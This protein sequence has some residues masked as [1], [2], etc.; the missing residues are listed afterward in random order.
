M[1]AAA[2]LGVR[3]Q[4]QQLRQ[5]RAS[6]NSSVKWD[7]RPHLDVVATGLV[8]PQFKPVLREHRPDAPRPIQPWKAGGADSVLSVL[9]RVCAGEL[10]RPPGLYA[11]PA[12]QTGAAE[13]VP[14]RLVT[15]DLACQIMQAS[16]NSLFSG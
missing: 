16:K 1:H 13:W 8:W 11:R 2:L 14:S 4:E 12:W 9:E 3:T 7:G 6:R 10:S 15:N 5:T